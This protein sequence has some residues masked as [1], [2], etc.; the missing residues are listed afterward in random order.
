MESNIVAAR[1]KVLIVAPMLFASVACLANAQ[2]SGPCSS[3][4]TG[5]VSNTTCTWIVENRKP[6]VPDLAAF[7][8]PG[9]SFSW[10]EGNFGPPMFVNGDVKT[11]RG[12]GVNIDISV[13][14]GDISGYSISW[15]RVSGAIENFS[16]F[17]F[18]GFP[19][20]AISS[21][22]KDMI[23]MGV[24]CRAIFSF[25]NRSGIVGVTCASRVLSEADRNEQ[26]SNLPG[27]ITFLSSYSSVY[28]SD[29]F[30]DSEFAEVLDI[31]E[32]LTSSGL[33]WAWP[34]LGDDVF[35]MFQDAS[36]DS[37]DVDP[38]F[39][40]FIELFGSRAVDL[41]VVGEFEL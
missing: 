21:S 29:R 6:K 41:I 4:T 40:R 34:P 2:T 28:L 38:S 20:K 16:G 9:V 11:Y 1:L 31:T 15:S 27:V 37:S 5:G 3:I 8:S 32:D 19:S 12:E 7:I 25:G 14:G 22:Y 39:S 26:N 33:L 35:D 17:G 23:A 18:S 36:L 13:K 24:P 10:V 30:N